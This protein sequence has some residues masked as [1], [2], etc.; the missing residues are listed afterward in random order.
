M[1]KIP[2]DQRFTKLN[3]LRREYLREQLRYGGEESS[4]SCSERYSHWGMALFVLTMVFLTAIF[5]VYFVYLRKP[6][7]DDH[8][9]VVNL[10]GQLEDYLQHTGHSSPAPPPTPS[11]PPAVDQEDAGGDGT[12]AR[13]SPGAER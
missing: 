5:V 10:Y 7:S 6:R 3:A 1:L 13:A 8:H 2:L 4:S 11:S 9:T 12:R